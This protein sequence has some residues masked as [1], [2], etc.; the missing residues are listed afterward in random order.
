MR[1]EG[2]SFIPFFSLLI[3]W[4]NT[5]QVFSTVAPW[6]PQLYCECCLIDEDSEP[7]KED[8]VAATAVG[9]PGFKGKADEARGSFACPCWPSPGNP[10]LQGCVCG[11]RKPSVSCMAV[12]FGFVEVSGSGFCFVFTTCC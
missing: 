5:L 3:T 1:G 4:N 11:Q 12:S 10:L 6:C 2:N 7:E 8:R 9:E